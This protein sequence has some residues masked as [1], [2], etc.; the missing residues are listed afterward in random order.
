MYIIFYFF[1]ESKSRKAENA[2][3]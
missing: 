3:K 2:T 1:S